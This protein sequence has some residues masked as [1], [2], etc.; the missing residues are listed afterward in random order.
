MAP[1]VSVLLPVYNAERYISDAIASIVAQT[2]TEFEFLIVDDGSTDDTPSI[3]SEWAERDTRIR[4][5]TQVNSGY[6]NALNKLL[7]DAQGE[8]IARI[9]A[10]DM[11]MPDRFFHQVKFL[12]AHPE[13]VV[14]G[15]S[16]IIIDEDGDEFCTEQL[17]EAHADIEYSLL[18]GSGGLCHPATMIRRDAIGKVGGYRAEYY[19][20]EDQ[21]LWLR[22]AERGYL[23]NLPAFLTKYRVHQNNFTFQNHIRSR[24]RLRASL[25]DAYTRRGIAMPPDLMTN[26]PEPT[27]LTERRRAWTWSAIRA[28]NYRTARKHA[29][30]GLFEEP[31]SRAAWVLAAYAYLGDRAEWL[32]PIFASRH[33]R[34]PE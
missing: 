21:D 28:H 5:N 7:V 14:V 2:F 10:D 6:V 29:R 27:T 32:R 30:T 22:L 20:A 24:E 31:C 33:G 15:S 3:L 11:S 17:P 18:R 8:Y 19:G 1:R 23:A 34:S 4:C 16:L 9:D 26:V 12:D 13:H 25:E